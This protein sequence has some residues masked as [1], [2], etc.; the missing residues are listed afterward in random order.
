MVV[1][2]AARMAPGVKGLLCMV[3]GCALVTFNDAILKWLTTDYPVGQIMFVRAIFVFP[4]ILLLALNEG[5]LSNLRV[6]NVKGH[7]V[8]SGIVVCG[9]F[10]FVTAISLMPIADALAIAFAAPLL[11]T[12]LAVPM[13]GERVG[14]RRWSA[15]IVGLCGVVVALKPTGEG[16]ALAALLPLG[17]AVTGALRDI[18]TRRLSVSDSSS[19]ILMVTT[20]AVMLAGLVSSLAPVVGWHAVA[21]QA[22]TWEHIGLLA[23]AGVLL[24][25]AQYLMIEAVRYA[26]IGLVA[27]FKYT[28]IVWAVILGY[29]VF[30][31]V[32]D[33]W[34]VTGSTIVIA[35]GLYIL[36]RETTLNTAHRSVPDRPDSA[37]LD[38]PPR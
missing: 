37:P 33:V 20:V 14:W 12:V 17:A 34:I 26:E 10:L 2:Q 1:L 24:A 31:T 36:H 11:G 28:S 15:V 7:A 27:P 23:G 6:R 8:R 21:W 32:P 29:L 9:M 38:R 18:V 13:L 3:A 25:G 5:G 22:M 35:S 30:D 19:S 4:P 16:I